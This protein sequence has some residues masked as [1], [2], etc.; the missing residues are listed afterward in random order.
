LRCEIGP[1][2]RGA[3]PPAVIRSNAEKTEFQFHL[4]F[5]EL[6]QPVEFELEAESA[7]MLMRALQTL[8]ARYKIPIPSEARLRGRPK[9]RIVTPDD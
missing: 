9:L 8:Q 4:E 7:M 6:P 2:R 3:R 1:D 5:P